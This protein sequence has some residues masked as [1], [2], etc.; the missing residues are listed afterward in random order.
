MSRL[1]DHFDLIIAI[2]LP[3]RE[4]RRAAARKN[5]T[6]TGLAAEGD[7][8]WLNACRPDHAGGPPRGWTAC[9]PAWGCL[10]SHLAAFDL[11]MQRGV[12]S[13][14]IL[15]DDCWFSPRAPQMLRVFMGAV[16]RHWGQIYL[17]GNH[18]LQ[19]RPTGHPLVWQAGGVTTTH[20]YAVAGH[21]LSLVRERMADM[22]DYLA[23]RGWHCDTHLALSHAQNRW[24]AYTPTWWMAA[25]EDSVSD[26]NGK[27]WPRRWLHNSAWCME[28]PFILVADPSAL[29]AE[30]QAALLFHDEPVPQS[31]PALLHWMHKSACRS[32]VYGRLPALPGDK[33]PALNDLRRLWPAGIIRHPGAD[34]ATLADYPFNG[35]FPH[36]MC[37]ALGAA[38]AS[39]N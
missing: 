15:E 14:L 18:A 22:A 36:A 4:D 9:K 32:L 33:A 16:P 1:A 37:A 19:P 10:Q 7:I 24:P 5:L 8:H 20:A 17:G 28:L 3:E 27:H 25:Q 11:A 34:L 38:P 6:E 12:Q 21:S 23:Y 30:E 29:T 2:S 13:V 39:R 35:L 26:L 31:L